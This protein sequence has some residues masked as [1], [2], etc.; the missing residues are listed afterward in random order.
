MFLR[1]IL[2]FSS[3][4]TYAFAAA[5]VAACVGLGVHVAFAADGS[6][7]N[8]VSLAAWVALFAPFINA[9]AAALVSALVGVLL[10]YV[11]KWIGLSVDDKNRAALASAAQTAA[12]NVL[13]SIEGDLSQK[14]FT[15]NNA[16]V[17]DAVR[18]VERSAPGAI[19]HFGLSPDDL[20]QLVLG[21]I[22]AL[23]AQMTP[24]A[25]PK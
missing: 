25:T 11:N 10:T 16:V 13:A 3:L 15:I 8:S 9:L 23:Q 22:G 5:L 4:L 21:K 17:R 14:S 7:D 12:G 18:W 24:A 2:N 19:A 6:P 20:A 1:R